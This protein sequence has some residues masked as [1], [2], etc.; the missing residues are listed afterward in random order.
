L[1]WVKYVFFFCFFDAEEA[2]DK[3]LKDQVD[4]YA[5]LLFELQASPTFEYTKRMKKEFKELDSEVQ[6]EIK[7]DL[8]ELLREQKP[9]ASD[10]KIAQRMDRILQSP[11]GFEHDEGKPEEKRYAVIMA[12]A[13]LQVRQKYLVAS[14]RR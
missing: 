2:R 11:L 9:S 13:A 14:T 12:R 3:Q 10:K 7:A 4:D 6:D 8:E 5:R 1:W